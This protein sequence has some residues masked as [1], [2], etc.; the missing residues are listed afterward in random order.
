LVCLALQGRL[1]EISAT[2]QRE[3]TFNLAD[4]YHN[5]SR[6]IGVDTLKLD[7]IAAGDILEA[8]RPGFK[9][10]DY[11]PPPIAGIFPLTDVA[12]AYR[13]VANG[14]VA[15]DGQAGRIVLRPRG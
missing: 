9:A 14:Q 8:L 1:S 7:L 6:I 12:A 4:F 3:V 11:R 15:A 13:A 5:E 2:G 10:G